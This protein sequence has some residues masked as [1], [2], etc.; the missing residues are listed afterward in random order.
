MGVEGRE[1]QGAKRVNGIT[2]LPGVRNMRLRKLLKVP[3]ILEVRGS[4]DSIGVMLAKM[5]NHEKM[6]PE[7]ATS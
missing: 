2:W 3:E 4:Q 1:A 6:E 7:E 5:P